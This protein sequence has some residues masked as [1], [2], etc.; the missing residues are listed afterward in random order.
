MVGSGGR[1][2]VGS[3][4]LEETLGGA[5]PPL[6]SSKHLLQ[7][8]RLLAPFS[9][10]GQR[11]RERERER[12]RERE[13]EREIKRVRERRREKERERFTDARSNALYLPSGNL[14]RSGPERET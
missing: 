4:C 8:A 5:V 14:P 12:D 10:Q 6:R 2:R 3:G 1:E 11:E 7:N 13:R 9:S